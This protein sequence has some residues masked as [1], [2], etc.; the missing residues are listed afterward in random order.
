MKCERLIERIKGLPAGCA[1]VAP[2][3]SQFARAVG[4]ARLAIIPPNLVAPRQKVRNTADAAK[5]DVTP[6]RIAAFD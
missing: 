4:A 3:C 6:D 1:A 2:A 5:L